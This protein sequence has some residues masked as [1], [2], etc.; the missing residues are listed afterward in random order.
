VVI[1]TI[2]LLIVANGAPNLTKNGGKRGKF[3]IGLSPA[4]ESQ[5]KSESQNID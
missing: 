4:A 5:A 3:R 2:Q 1:A